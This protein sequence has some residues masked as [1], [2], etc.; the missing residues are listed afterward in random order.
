MFTL[1][2]AVIL[3]AIEGITEFLPISST[4]HLMLATRALGIPFSAFSTTFTIAIQSGA[5]LAVVALYFRTLL[6]WHTLTKLIVAFIPTGII[7]L[8]L[9]PFISGT[10]LESIPLVLTTLALGGALLI[11]FEYAHAKHPPT[12]VSEYISYRQA[13]GIGI[14]QSFAM[15]PGVSRAAA[16]II[17]GML[18]G[19]SRMAMVEFSF[20]LAVPTMLAA[21]ALDLYKHYTLFTRDEFTLLAVGFITAFITALIAITWLLKFMQTHS[22]AP[23][24]WY[25]I[26]LALTVLVVLFVF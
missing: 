21:T 24:G 18:M 25:R 10:A 4:A 8:A 20:L 5:I 13:I 3:G 9:Y 7:G 16:T 17:G 1:I 22:F 11:L 12:D 15:I 23:F 26:L 6:N 14:A 19:V 2:H